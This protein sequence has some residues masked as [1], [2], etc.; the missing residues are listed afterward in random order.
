MFTYTTNKHFYDN[1]FKII[2]SQQ[3][4]YDNYVQV[5]IQ[6]IFCI[7]VLCNLLSQWE[8]IPWRIR[9]PFAK[10]NQLQQSRAT[11]A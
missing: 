6:N 5:D 1:M 8:C 7:C 9:V 3:E 2:Y 10:E 4:P 11:Q